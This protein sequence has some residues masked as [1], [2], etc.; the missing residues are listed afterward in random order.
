[1]V[2]GLAKNIIDVAVFGFGMHSLSFG[3]CSRHALCTVG[4]QN[5][6]TLRAVGNPR[7]SDWGGSGWEPSHLD[8][9]RFPCRRPRRSYSLLKLLL[10]IAVGMPR[11]AKVRSFFP[12]TTIQT[13][14]E[15]F[16]IP[17]SCANARQP[18][19]EKKYKTLGM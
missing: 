1:M 11:G 6:V 19:P 15:V 5:S 9:L 7:Y 13:N 4:R 14:R 18:H 3:N 12:T 16:S 10:K 2:G 8:G 17:L